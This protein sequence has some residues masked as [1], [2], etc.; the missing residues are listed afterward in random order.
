MHFKSQEEKLVS[1]FFITPYLL[2]GGDIGILL[3]ICR[4]FWG[5]QDY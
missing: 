1:G 5:N 4:V 3:Y 2:F